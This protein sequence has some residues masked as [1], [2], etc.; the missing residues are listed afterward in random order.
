MR[1]SSRREASDPLPLVKRGEGMRERLPLR[2]FLAGLLSLSLSACQTAAEKAAPQETDAPEKRVELDI[3]NPKVEISTQFEQMAAVYE[4]EHPNVL[5]SVHTVGGAADDLTD[6]KAQI[7]AGN[8]PDIFTNSGFEN[9]RLWK[10]YLEDLSDQPWVGNAYEDALKPIRIDGN[11]Y[12]LPLNLEGYGF[13]YNK[14]LFRKAG[15]ESLPKTLSELTAAAEQLQQAGITPFATG[16]YEE[17]KLGVH[18]LNIAFAQQEDPAAFIK[19][20]NDGTEKLENNPAFN[21]LISLLDLTLKYGNPNPLST[22]YNMEVN[23]F[24]EGEAAMIQQG[25]WVQ[26]MIDQLSPE[27]NIGFLPLPINDQRKND[28]LV[29]NVP[30]YWVVNK[31]TTPEKKKEAKR[32]L[33]WMVS[34]EQGKQFMTE[35]FKFI[36]AFKN[37]KADHLGP[38]ARETIRYYNAGKTLDSNWF[39]FPVEV[40]EEFGLAMQLYVGKQLNREQ[41]LHEF[42]KSWDKARTHTK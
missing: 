20:L 40:R 31:Q 23:I 34:S 27:M 29:V 30:N 3:R 22:D 15:I 4:K 11:V 14:D 6:L 17:W 5:I 26:P 25:N 10:G 24:A 18:L 36:P 38:L 1:K 13:I 12:G 9:A 8:G 2:M 39:G 41:L 33:N 16:Y 21:D 37:I 42:Q 35:E 28:A 32:F 19:G 7:A